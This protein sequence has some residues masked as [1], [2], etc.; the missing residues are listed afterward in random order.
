[1]SR[2]EGLKWVWR[3]ASHNWTDLAWK[4]VLIPH[5]ESM[6][7]VAAYRTAT[8][9][10]IDD[11]EHDAIIEGGEFTLEHSDYW[12]VV[13]L[14]KDEP[15][16][17]LLKSNYTWHALRK[18]IILKCKLLDIERR[19]IERLNTEF[20]ADLNLEDTQDDDTTDTTTTSQA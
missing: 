13:Y 18:H 3:G 1:M 16:E 19:S 7:W 12:H 15:D 4:P 10:D 2:Y 11:V 8:E 17:F 5:Y 6:N 14:P 9:G 20:R